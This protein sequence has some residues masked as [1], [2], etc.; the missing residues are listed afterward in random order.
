M[1]QKMQTRCRQPYLRL[2]DQGNI[3][4]QHT[5]HGQALSI[6]RYVVPDDVSIAAKVTFPDS[7]AQ[8]H[9]LRRIR[10]LVALLEI[11]PEQQRNSQSLKEARRNQA[12]RHLFG[13]ISGEIRRP[14]HDR[15]RNACHLLKAPIR[16]PII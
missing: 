4:R 10:L 3:G 13:L 11:A 7:I 15:L 5:N 12:C 9:D 1:H 8:D 2:A 14:G 16:I 6:Q